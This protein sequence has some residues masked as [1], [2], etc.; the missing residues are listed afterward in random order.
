MTDLVGRARQTTAALQTDRWAHDDEL[1]TTTTATTDEEEE[2][3]E[4]EDETMNDDERH[5]LIGNLQGP[6]GARCRLTPP[7]GPVGASNDSNLKEQLNKLV[8]FVS[9]S[10]APGELQSAGSQSTDCDDEFT[11]HKS[12]NRQLGSSYRNYEN[13]F[14]WDQQQVAPTRSNSVLEQ[15]R[16]QRGGKDGSAGGEQST[17]APR[18]LLLVAILMALLIASVMLLV[19]LLSLLEEN[20]GNNLFAPDPPTRQVLLAGVD[21]AHQRQLGA[22][23]SARWIISTPKCHIPVLDPWDE[24]IK[25]YVRV[26]SP[27][28]CSSVIESSLRGEL[29][30]V[31]EDA[32]SRAL[33]AAKT[34]SYVRANRLFFTQQALD[35]GALEGHCCFRRVER[36]DD[37]D[38][39]LDVEAH[40]RPLAEQGYAITAGLVRVTCLAFNYT[41]VHAFIRHDQDEEGAL[42]KIAAG[43]LDT[44]SYYNVLMV[45]VDTMSRLN[46]LRQLNR[47]LTLLRNLYQTLDFVGYN[48]VGENTFPNLIPLLTGLK[49]EQLTQTQCWLATN[50]SQDSDRG[51]DYLDNCKYL[52]NFYQLFGY[53]TY[54][55]EDWPSASTFN[56]LKPGFKH[57][58]TSHYGRPF[59]LARRKLL[60]PKFKGIG[61]AACQLD[62]PIAG[63]DLSNLKAFIE[64]HSGRPHF[65]FHWINCPQHDDLNGA[66]QVDHLLERF[67]ADLHGIT[68][69]ERTFVIFFSDHGYRWNN[70]VSTRIGHYES[71]LPL[72][73]IAPPRLFR[74]QYPELVERLKS[75]QSAL[76]TPFDMFK[77]LIDVLYLGR[78]RLVA[79]KSVTERSATTPVEDPLVGSA[80]TA[81]TTIEQ[82]AVE[83]GLSFKQDFRIISLLEHHEPDELDRSCI[84]AGIPDNYCVCHQFKNVSTSGL[85]VLG[86]AYF[87]VYIHLEERL[88]NHPELCH[89]LELEAV[90]KAEMFDMS[91]LQASTKGPKQGG[92]IDGGGTTTTSR[93][94]EPVGQEDR[95]HYMPAR[96]YNVLLSTKPG[97]GLFQE[98]IRFYGADMERCRAAVARARFI[99]EVD[100]WAEFEERKLIVRQ[101]NS[102]CQFRIRSDSISRL[103]LYKEQSKCVKSNI[104]LKKICYCKS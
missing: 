60:W 56:Y 46:G 8:Q 52:W 15:R 69:D 81:S 21:E 45:G 1:K 11:Y 82:L 33:E 44:D 93:P 39:D 36:R 90:H 99:V 95:S 92:L 10:V 65:A 20:R 85:D 38:D 84:E 104:E 42:E 91:H 26:K 54:F 34:L 16:R 88:S 70:F 67:F 72:M 59:T 5:L 25:G 100:R 74:E 98:V 14:S 48:K 73:T 97:G 31:T 57:A 103:N 18:P 68:Q 7:N 53:V 28:N 80:P 78:Q 37:N 43:T 47:T 17:T 51:D 77:T 75:H 32:I 66:S 4:E 94:A 96:E 55:S 30:N 3:E 49:P 83:D 6:I 102:I 2:E 19:K 24:S 35:L 29:P 58:P 89:E 61:C 87:L 9:K 62:K 13:A 27:L 71:S 86:A 40:C 64:A 76:L 63:I 12:A 41:N 50:Y 23:Q 22:E 101:M 79:S